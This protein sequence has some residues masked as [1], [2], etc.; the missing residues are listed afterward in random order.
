M[1]GFLF[2]MLLMAGIALIGVC[3]FLLIDRLYD[4]LKGK[5]KS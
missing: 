2:Y 1:D 3:L 5:Q 4:Y